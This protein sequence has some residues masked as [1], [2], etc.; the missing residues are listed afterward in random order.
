MKTTSVT[1]MEFFSKVPFW[2]YLMTA[3]FKV[4]S[5]QLQSTLATTFEMMHYSWRFY[6][7]GSPHDISFSWLNNFKQKSA[8]VPGK[9]SFKQ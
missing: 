3:M 5:Q 7:H 8:K 2:N 9:L 6:G 4:L 1:N